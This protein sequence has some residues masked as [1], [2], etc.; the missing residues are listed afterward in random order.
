MVLSLY[1]GRKYQRTA[2]LRGI[3][4][5]N[6]VF[7]IACIFWWPS[8]SRYLA[9]AMRWATWSGIDQAPQLFD[10]PFVLLWLLPMSG[11]TCA[12]MFERADKM[13]VACLAATVPMLLL[14]L[15]FGWYH[16]APPQ[17]Q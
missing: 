8:L 7:G 12:W 15:I 13:R 16:F 14:G 3:M 17:W 1:E 4:A 10:Y 11:I 2:L 5:V 6:V 9:D